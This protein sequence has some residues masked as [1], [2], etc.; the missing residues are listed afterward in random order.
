MTTRSASAFG[1]RRSLSRATVLGASAVF[2][3][4]GAAGAAQAKDAVATAIY[5]ANGDGYPVFVTENGAG[6]VPGTYAI[7]TIMVDY[8]VTGFQFPTDWQGS[9][10]MCL[11]SRQATSTGRTTQYPA[12]VYVKQVG[13]ADLA[14]GGIP[15]TVNFG[16]VNDDPDPGTGAKCVNVSAKVPSA[17]AG[18]PSLQADGTTLV[19]NLQELTDSG[20]HL[21]TPTTVKVRVTLL[22][23]TA[24]VRAVHLV[25]NNDFTEDLGVAGITESIGAPQYKLASKPVDLQH[26]LTVVNTCSEAQTVDINAA[27][28]ENFTV[29]QAN[30]IRTT[31]LSQEVADAEELLGAGLSWDDMDN[32]NPAEMCLLNV[33]IPGN[34]SFIFTQRMRVDEDGN[35]PG[36][37]AASLGRSLGSWAYDGFRYAM[38]GSDGSS[39]SC[40]V[41]GSADDSGE[42]S[43]P[44]TSVTSQGGGKP[45][46]QFA[47]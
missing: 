21:D 45:S 31:S 4:L 39:T 11:D 22:H 16:G 15:A 25:A 6:M 20:A 28:N 37:T 33:V 23:P 19:A 1:G 27:I 38:N 32:V 7:G 42:V 41:F 24:C 40:P 10:R 29:F 46:T 14:I 44:V 43:V 18:D 47:P 5:D 26:L 13:A 9:F 8:F 2:A 36:D 35:F 17:V 3:L 12:N 34:Q 30:G